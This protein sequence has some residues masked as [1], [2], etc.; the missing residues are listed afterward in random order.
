LKRP[1]LFHRLGAKVCLWLYV[2]S[3]VYLTRPNFFARFVAKRSCV[4]DIPLPWGEQQIT[5]GMT[6][7][8]YF[9]DL[10]FG[11][12][13]PRSCATLFVGL[14]LLGRRSYSTSTAFKDSIG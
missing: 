2:C 10:N 12:Y 6:P 3:K 14:F 11:K 7:L 8:K 9:H 13:F 4:V 1:V 5:R